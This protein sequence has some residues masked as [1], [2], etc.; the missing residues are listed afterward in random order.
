MKKIIFAALALLLVPIL[1]Y[2]QDKTGYDIS[3]EKPLKGRTS[4]S[5]MSEGSLEFKNSIIGMTLL[6]GG[7]FT[8]GTTGG[9]AAGSL[10]NDCQLTFGHPYAMTSYP[11][12]SVDGSWQKF[13]DLNPSEVTLARTGDT[14]KVRALKEGIFSVTFSMYFQASDS[15]M[16]LGCEVVNLDSVSHSFGLGFILDPALGRWGDAAVYLDGTTLLKESKTFSVQET[17]SEIMLWEKSTGAKGLSAALSF[18]SKPDKMIFANWAD[19]FK[20]V[21]PD[22]DNSSPL[23]LYDCLIKTYWNETQVSPNEKKTADMV[24]S[25][26]KPDF[27]SATFLRWDIPQ[28]FALNNGLVFPEK[29]DTYLELNKTGNTSFTNGALQLSLP[30]EMTSSKTEYSYGASVPG[31]QNLE[32]TP[33]IIYENKIAEVSVKLL[34]G[35]NVIDEIHRFVFIPAT[36]VS[37]SGLIVKI[38]TLMSSRFPSMALT[39][40]VTRED[41]GNKITTL[42]PENI[43][44]YENSSRITDFTFGKD[45]SGG[46]TSADIVFVLDVTGSMGNEIDAVKN[47]IIEFADNLSK[48]GID[49]QLGLVTFLDEVENKYPFTKDVQAFQQNIAAQY[50]H[51]GGDGPEN[52]LQALLDASRFNFRQ[53][54]KRIVVWITD[55]EYHENDSY[56][57]LK[58]QTVIDSLLINGIVVNAIGEKIFKSDFYDP[59]VIPTGGNYYDITGNFRDIL[60]DISRMKSNYKYL[61][62]YRSSAQSGTN[63]VKLQVRFAGLGGQAVINYNTAPKGIAEKRL[64]FY[65]NPFNP[66]ITFQVRKGEFVKG[67]IRIYNVL[68]QKVREFELTENSMQKLVWNAR[69]DHGGMVGAGFYFAELT[70]TDK[71]NVSY[72]ETAKILYLK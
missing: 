27:S 29:L 67:K 65:P 26:R 13:D 51:G 66:E 61:I 18:S 34:D 39:F 30:S 10:D 48:E 55:A 25:L 37:D 2:A 4:N 60:L 8:L 56:T 54:S 21:S 9:T 59:I 28:F 24:I 64:A 23:T 16:R 12:F 15:T 38:D 33:R 42:A 41:K 49:Y 35:T 7:Y 44:L 63:E 62:S 68:G 43:F 52:S 3:T 53:N 46:A 20:S 40:E 5:I 32:V 45:T 17:P 6:K 1:S 31:Y 69:N 11:A 71:K 72:S 22:F 57:S 36:P 58:R 70:L 47:N 50:A 14:L 19:A